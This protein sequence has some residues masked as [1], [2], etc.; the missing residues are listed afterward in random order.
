MDS[1]MG[2]MTRKLS[3]AMVMIAAL[4]LAVGMPGQASASTC[5][6]VGG[7]DVGGDCTISTPIT[8]FCP[9]VLTDP[10]GSADHR[11]RQHQ[12]R[13]SRVPPE[14]GQPITIS[15]GGDMEMR[16]GSSIRAENIADGGN[17]GNITLTV[18]GNFTMRGTSGGTAGAVISSSKTGRRRQRGREHSDHRRQRHGQPG[19]PDHHM[20]HDARGRHPGGERRADPAPM[21]MARRAPSRCLRART[22]RSTDWS[23]RVGP[24]GTAGEGGPITIDA[25]C[26]LVVGDTG[27]VI[28]RG[29]D[30]GADLVHLQGCVVHIFGLVASTGPAHEPPFANLCNVN[31]PGKPADS[32]ACV[33]IW[34]GTT[35]MIDSTG[36]HKGEVNADTGTS[37]GTAGHAV[38]STSWRTA[39]SRSG[40]TRRRRAG[41]EQQ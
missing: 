32:G 21:R 16:A 35:L 12:L 3:L 27:Q 39:R 40:A 6:H 26:D 37:G 8:A 5:T 15:V 34:S 23:R 10:G 30:P 25:C 22:P 28:S 9:F 19:R 13:R 33:E 29:R 11:H 41:G 24:P 2:K 7:T 4:V 31:R 20:R 1:G 36:T 14:P 17:G 18:G 38:G